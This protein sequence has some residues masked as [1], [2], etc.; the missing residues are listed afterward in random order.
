[1]GLDYDE[2]R[3]VSKRVR[4]AC[5]LKPAKKGRRLPR[6][7]T[8][9]EFR[10]FY[11]VVDKA[12]DAQHAL[13]LRLLFFT[14]VRVSELCNM[15]VADVD[16][17]TCKIR[18]NQGK[19]AKDR[20]VLFGRSFSTALRTHIAAHPTN[21]YLFQTRRNSKYTSRRVQQIVRFYAEKA[22]VKATHA[23]A[24]PSAGAKAPPPAE[25]TAPT[26]S[27]GKSA[28][29][30]TGTA[31]VVECATPPGCFA[32]GVPVAGEHGP[33]PIEAVSATMK[34][35]A[36]DEHDPDGPLVLCEVEEVFER[37]SL[38]WEVLAANGVVIRT[39]AEHPFWVVSRGWTDVDAI[40]PGERLVGRDGA[41]IGIESVRNTGRYERVYNFR[42][43]G[44]HTYFVGCPEW[45]F[46]AWTHNACEPA[47]AGG[48]G[49]TVGNTGKTHTQLLDDARAARD[50]LAATV[51]KS[52]KGRPATVTGGYNVETGE[53]AA[54][55]SG[56]R[57]GGRVC[58]ECHVTDALGGD[59]SAV[60][61]AEAVRPRP[62]APYKEVPVC[63][64]CEAEFGR[65]AFPPHTLF[66]TDLFSGGSGI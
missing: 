1:M 47:G 42:V 18:I 20:Y 58:A 64:E 7:L 31:E 15:L 51:G 48:S 59:K 23:D 19:G 2:W 50:A 61:L 66:D 12:D 44:A 41:E 49:A 26:T 27:A 25:L 52:P 8:G 38:V 36:R 3:Y 40:R 28:A 45:G 32:V 53:V 13:M 55:A 43:A 5:D 10:K 35:W 29:G 63:P 30:K 62:T 17:D 60:Q 9:D 37:F 22:G 16:L 56:P 57:A 21:R 54:A 14:G 39:T 6:V 4:Q 46:D 34:V 65:P 33:V 24:P 11:A